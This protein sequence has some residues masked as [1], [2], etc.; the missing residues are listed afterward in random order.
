MEHEQVKSERKFLLLALVSGMCGSA[1]LAT[2][3]FQWRGVFD[4]PYSRICTGRT[5]LLS[6][7]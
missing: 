1:T 6:I 3:F 2:V 5:C 4:L 7:A